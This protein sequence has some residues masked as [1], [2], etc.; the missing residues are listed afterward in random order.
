MV[1][2]SFGSLS[3]MKLVEK[4]LNTLRELSDTD[5]S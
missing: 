4:P 2:T 3:L 5:L 1:S